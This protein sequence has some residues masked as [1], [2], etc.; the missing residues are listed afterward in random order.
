[1]NRLL[2]IFIIATFLLVLN[3]ATS[4]AGLAT[5]NIPITDQKYTV[6]SPVETSTWWL[7]F[8]IGILGFP[9]SKPPVHDLVQATIE[10]KEAD[11]LINI[12]HW[13]DKIVILFIT[14][15]RFGLN[16]EAVRFESAPPKK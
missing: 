13:N 1:M 4:S 8:D 10:E 14:I 7:S 6:I 3:C 9:L 11:A 16:A 12:R 15:N 2:S 5:S